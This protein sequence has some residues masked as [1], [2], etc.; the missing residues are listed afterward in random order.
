MRPPGRENKPEAARPSTSVAARP[1]DRVGPTRD[2]ARLQASI[3]NQAVL[4]LQAARTA[5][6]GV[7]TAVAGLGNQA[8]LRFEQ[9]LG[10][11]LAGVHVQR[12]ADA[13]ASVGAHALTDG[14]RISIGPGPI[15]DALL[16][17]ELAHVAQH[18]NQGGQPAG[19][20]PLEAEARAMAA[21][22]VAGAPASP[23]LRPAQPMQLADGPTPRELEELRAI[24]RPRLLAAR[25]RIAELRAMQ[26]RYA[27]IADLRRP[28][29]DARAALDA[30]DLSGPL[31]EHNEEDVPQLNTR[32][33]F[34]EVSEDLVRITIRFQVR[35]SGRTDAEAERLFPTLRAS[36]ISGIPHAWDQTLG[37]GPLAGRELAVVPQVTLVAATSR[38]DP[39]AFLVDVRPTD[40]GVPTYGGTTLTADPLVQQVP[41]SIT[42][43]ALDGGVMSIPPGHIGRPEIL[44]H[45]TAHLLGLQDRYAIVTHRGTRSLQSTRSFPAGDTR[46]DLL[47]GGAPDAV[48]LGEDLDVVFENFGVY[49]VEAQ[50][51]TTPYAATRRG[52]AH[53]RTGAPRMV[54]ASVIDPIEQ[55]ITRQTIEVE[56]ILG[57]P[58]WSGARAP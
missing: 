37:A 9:Q 4:R 54:A 52:T 20:E 1:P 41:T 11:D 15:D 27:A 53:H 14:D 2:A 24:D 12:D 44:A 17:H 31:K 50:R 39:T 58:W 3:G 51:G 21:S 36:L 6:P 30:G 8:M 10:L 42:E 7:D 22:L 34:V 45:E 5:P 32:P 23:R 48:V 55:E 38:R 49:D 16:A 19:R 57:S 29:R 35:F 47:A 43:A 25:R 18:R 40:L 33:V 56:A 28:V 26:R 46:V 13:V